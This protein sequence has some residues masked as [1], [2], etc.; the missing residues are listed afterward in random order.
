MCTNATFNNISVISWRSVLLVE[1]TGIP[2][3]NHW[4]TLSHNVV[5]SKLPER[6]S[7]S[8]LQTQCQWWW[9]L[10]AYR[11]VVV[12]P[13]TCT[14]RSRPTTAPVVLGFILSITQ[15]PILSHK[16]MCTDRQYIYAIQPVEIHVH[17]NQYCPHVYQ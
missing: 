9:A 6:D 13:T 4:Q 12:N 11:Y 5:S 7:N 17:F 10:I 16:C 15:P 2:R 14:I 3:E 1:E 8:Q